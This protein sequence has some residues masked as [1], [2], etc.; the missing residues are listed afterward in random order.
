MKALT[1]APVTAFMLLKKRT[2]AWK[3][4]VALTVASD[5]ETGG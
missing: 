3:G 5:E 2:D 4:S 1:A